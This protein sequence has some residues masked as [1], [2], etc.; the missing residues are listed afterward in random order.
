MLFPFINVSSL[1]W[2]VSIS[3]QPN[4]KCELNVLYVEEIAQKQKLVSILTA[5]FPRLNALQRIPGIFFEP[6]QNIPIL[7]SHRIIPIP[8]QFLKATRDAAFR[9]YVEWMIAERWDERELMAYQIVGTHIERTKPLLLTF[10]FFSC[11]DVLQSTFMP[12]TA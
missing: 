6:S 1:F 9:Q 2:L 11:K 12:S 5:S 4:I 3:N 10:T 7:C 8:I